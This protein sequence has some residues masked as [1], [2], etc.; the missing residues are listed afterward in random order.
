MKFVKYSSVNTTEIYQCLEATFQIASCLFPRTVMN[1]AE[2]R[3]SVGFGH[4]A[5]QSAASLT[6]LQD[7]RTEIHS[8]TSYFVVSEL[9][10]EFIGEI[11]I[12]SA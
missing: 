12:L 5:S 6:D 8:L 4:V 2:I 7:P 1:F 10:N 9:L 11:N 3:Y